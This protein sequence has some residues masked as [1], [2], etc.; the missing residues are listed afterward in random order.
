MS[1]KDWQWVL[2][3]CQQRWSQAD[4]KPGDPP[5]SVEYKAEKARIF[6]ELYSLA[7]PKVN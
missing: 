5:P 4:P 1:P 2:Q 3:A 7:Y 6:K